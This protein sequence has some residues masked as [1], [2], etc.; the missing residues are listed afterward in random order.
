MGTQQQTV[1]TN[2]TTEELEAVRDVATDDIAV[3]N[4]HIADLHAAK[5]T[6]NV[7][8]ALLLREGQLAQA[9]LIQQ[10][11]ITLLS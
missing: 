9:Y 11:A 1:M 5:Q 3:L 4:A 7:R 8:A 6:R 2:M 10:Q